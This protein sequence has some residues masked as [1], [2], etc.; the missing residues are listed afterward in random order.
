MKSPPVQVADSI[1]R[2]NTEE[3]INGNA[4]AVKLPAGEP[5]LKVEEAAE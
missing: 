3:F 4:G 5:K 1:A 2:T